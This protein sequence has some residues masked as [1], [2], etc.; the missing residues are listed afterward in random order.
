MAEEKTISVPDMARRLG[1][2][3][4]SVYNYIDRGIIRSKRVRRG[5]RERIVVLLSDFE[6]A[7]PRLTGEID[8]GDI[9]D[10]NTPEDA[11]TPSLAAAFNM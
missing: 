6:A 11:R 2:T 10:S 5:L 4:A 7:L 8:S 3:N 1:V 9:L